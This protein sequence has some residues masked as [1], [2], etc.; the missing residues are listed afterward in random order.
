MSDR[1]KILLDTDIG[2]DIDD[3]VCL[4]YL[5]ANPACSLQGITTVT[6]DPL[7]RAKM[8]S[9]LCKVA[10]QDIPIYPGLEHPMLGG[11]TQQAQ[12]QQASALAKWPHATQFPANQAARFM[13]DTIRRNPG[14]IVLLTIGPLTNAGVLFAMDPELPSLLRGLVMMCGFFYHKAWHWGQ[15]AEWNAKLDAHATAIVYRHAVRQHRSI[16]LD[17]TTQVSLPADEV[18]RRFRAPLLRTVL[19]FAE[20]WFSTQNA[21]E[22]L[23]HDPLA[24]ATI[25]DDT[26]CQFERGTVDVELASSRVAGLTHWAPGAGPHEVAKEVDSARFFD[27]YFSMFA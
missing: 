27:H 14:E 18:R 7:T 16:G 13:Q 11:L 26:I 1:I 20:V 12:V 23:F 19:D 3:A 6:G 25:F 17:V 8:A 4:A 10:G 15:V 2:S 22:I 21:K 5:L 24:A 9:A